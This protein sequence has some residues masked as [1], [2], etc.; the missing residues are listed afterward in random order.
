MRR[1]APFEAAGLLFFMESPVARVNYQRDK[2]QKDLARQRKQEEKRQRK[3]QKDVDSPGETAEGAA[4]E[5]GETGAESTAPDPEG[6][7]HTP[8]G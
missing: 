6:S 4:I 5:E 1:P 2:R 7:P 8:E 3:L